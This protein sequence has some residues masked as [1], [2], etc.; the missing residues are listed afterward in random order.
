MFDIKA[1]TTIR[2][3]TLNR[4][5]FEECSTDPFSPKYIPGLDEAVKHAQFY[6]NCRNNGC[7]PICDYKMLKK[8]RSAHEKHMHDH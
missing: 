1:L 6:I 2:V 7:V 5:F 3:L 8:F 4:E